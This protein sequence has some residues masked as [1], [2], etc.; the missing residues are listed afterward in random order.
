MMGQGDNLGRVIGDF[1]E[2]VENESL[3]P[4]VRETL[5]FENHPDLVMFFD[6]PEHFL[7][8]L[9]HFRPIR[10]IIMM[11][12][13]QYEAQRNKERKK[14]SNLTIGEMEVE[15]GLKHIPTNQEETDKREKELNDLWGIG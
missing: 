3:M 14:E 6:P 4:V 15:L 11:Q 12:M 2:L 8:W 7:N 9:D 10:F 5:K 1:V 13:Q